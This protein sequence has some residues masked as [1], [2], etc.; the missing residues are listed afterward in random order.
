MIVSFVS[1][2]PSMQRGGFWLRRCIADL[3]LTDTKLACMCTLLY[4]ERVLCCSLCIYDK[5]YSIKRGV[6]SSSIL[7]YKV[8][9]KHE[10]GGEA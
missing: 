4:E 1:V 3:Q 2:M 7:Q 8:L 6:I 9:Y 5:M 10:M